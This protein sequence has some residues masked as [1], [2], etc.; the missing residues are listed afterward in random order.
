MDFKRQLWNFRGTA[1]KHHG[2]GLWSNTC[3]THPR[4]YEIPADD[5][6]PAL[7]A[8]AMAQNSWLGELL[9]TRSEAKHSWLREFLITRA[10]GERNPFEPT[11]NIQIVITEEEAE[12]A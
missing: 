12:E 1:H 2:A 3:C 8:R 6:P 11:E 7:A 9:E 4:P 5:E 10:Q